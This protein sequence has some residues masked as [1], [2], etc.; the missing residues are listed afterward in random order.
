[1]QDPVSGKITLFGGKIGIDPGLNREEVQ[2]LE[3]LKLYSSMG[4][5][6]QRGKLAADFSEAKWQLFGGAKQFKQKSSDML[7]MD[8]YAGIKNFIEQNVDE[9]K[10]NDVKILNAAG[11]SPGMRFAMDN[12]L[13]DNSPDARGFS[14]AADTMA[15]GAPTPTCE[16]ACDSV[17]VSMDGALSDS[18]SA[19][20]DAVHGGVVSKKVSG[21]SA[22]TKADTLP[23]YTN[24]SVAGQMRLLD[25]EKSADDQTS[26]DGGGYFLLYADNPQ[27]AGGYG[28]PEINVKYINPEGV[29]SS[30]VPSFEIEMISDPSAECFTQTMS[31]NKDVVSAMYT[32]ANQDGQNVVQMNV[33]TTYY[34]GTVESEVVTVAL[35]GYDQVRAYGASNLPKIDLAE[36][37]GLA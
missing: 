16:N 27:Q 12:M 34:D 17:S 37:I 28:D 33:E 4:D 2:E 23:D 35:D 32:N 18:F 13:S 14:V 1:M 8:A 10:R 29:E 31:P 21:L 22:K 30:E 36:H 7:E 11:D 24:Q 25:I 15:G 26:N 19:L 6:G 5:E 3:S 20:P 9:D